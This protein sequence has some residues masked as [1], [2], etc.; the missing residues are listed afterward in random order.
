MLFD[1]HLRAYR[2]LKPLQWPLSR[3]IRIRRPTMFVGPGS[4]RRLCT[5]LGQFGHRRVMIITDAMLV[6]LGLVAPLRDALV[7]QGA[8]VAVHDAI[9]PDPTWPVLQAGHQ[10][11]MAHRSDALLAVG[12]GSVIDAAKVIGAMAVTGKTPAQLVGRLKVRRP[13]L[14]LYAIG[15]FISFTLSQY[16]MVRHWLR[17][18]ESG[19]RTSALI[20]AI[21]AML[22]AVV[23]IVIIARAVL[24]K[25]Y[26]IAHPQ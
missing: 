23:F 6:Q 13:M 15:V 25:F 17:L 1:L 12:G 20:N 5:S 8:D 2:A 26:N 10:A 18:R 21:G 14:P 3:V 4:A 16:G 22:T 19:W 9:T 24:R 7:A 11:V